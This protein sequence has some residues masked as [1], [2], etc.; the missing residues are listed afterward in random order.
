MIPTSGGRFAHALPDSS[1][2]IW[3]P[4]GVDSGGLGG[5]VESIPGFLGGFSLP[6][7]DGALTVL[8]QTQ[9]RSKT[10]NFQFVLPLPLSYRPLKGA[11]L[12]PCVT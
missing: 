6:R 9:I 7:P 8:T 3:D 5:F 11:L 2:A 1:P 4:P 12:A 10:L